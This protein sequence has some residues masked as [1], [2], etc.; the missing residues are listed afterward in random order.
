[1][2]VVES[3]RRYDSNEGVWNSRTRMADCEQVRM[4]DL[5]PHR[6][7]IAV[8]HPRLGRG[9]S[10]LT[11]MWAIEALK[12]EHDI[13]LITGGGVDLI[14]LN[15]LCG[16]SLE[17]DEFT[18]LS[19]SPPLW[20]R[21]V[22]KA[23]KRGLLGGVL[24]DRMCINMAHQFDAVISAKNFC[25]CGVPAIHCIAHFFWDAEFRTSIHAGPSGT[26]EV[27]QKGST[28]GWLY[29]GLARA[30]RKSSGRNIFAGDDLI[31]ANSQ[32][33]ADKM[34]AKYGVHADVLYP[35]VAGQFPNTPWEQREN[36]CVCLSRID[37]IKRIERIIDVLDSVRRHNRDV[38]LHIIGQIGDDAYGRAI[39]SLCRTHSAWVIPEGELVGDAK[40]RL[41][42]SHRFGIHACEGEAFGIAV[43]EM[44]KAGC[45]TFV[46]N[47]GGPVEIV[48]HSCLTYTNIDDA[49]S[50]ICSVMTNEALR[51]DLRAHLAKQGQR[52]SAE[53][54]MAGLRDAVA[55]F[56]DKKR[57]CRVAC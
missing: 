10:E 9:G 47:G 14:G 40:F 45:I 11:A 3:V 12:D 1:M 53:A 49:V 44:V 24:Y 25:D 54:F 32:W 2:D 57:R 36:G 52:F 5:H 4:K 33:M 6:L 31:L 39:A 50:K 46:A 27:V 48:N 28:L 16:T 41:L 30:L 17:H 51:N 15:A 29:R 43:A 56:L 22:R 35:P 38:H 37:S 7:R 19:P 18:V 34:R 23:V 55:R 21:L 8:T 42:A 13:T 20:L 26:A